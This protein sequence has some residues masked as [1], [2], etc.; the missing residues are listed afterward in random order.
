MPRPASSCSGL[1]GT[2][3][4]AAIV[5]PAVLGVAAVYGGKE[6]L[7]E[8]RRRL[9]DRRQQART[10][11]ADLIEEIRFQVDGRLASV[12]DEMQR[13]M[14]ARFMDRIVELH[15]TVAASA[16]A[17][18]RAAKRE[19]AE[20]RARQAEVDGTLGID[21]RPAR[22]G[23]AGRDR[24]PEGR[25]AR[26]VPESVRVAS[27]PMTDQPADRDDRPPGTRSIDALTEDFRSRDY[28]AD[29]SLG[30]GRLPG[31]RARPSAPAGGRGRRRQD[32]ARQGPRRVARRAPDP[33]AV[34][35]G[36][37]RQHRGVRVE[38]PAPD[39]RDPSARGARGGRASQRPGHLRARLPHPP[40]AAPGA[41]ERRWGRPGAAHRRDRPG[42]RGVRGIPPRDPVGLPGHGAR[43]SARS[44]R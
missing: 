35:R 40:A 17:L 36:P 15:R 4:G 21:R 37:R 26:T 33:A 16:A 10:F 5:G 31:A 32:R 2:L 1:V 28:I 41:R 38:L 7:D 6:V 34:L 22:S 29:R 39:A 9:T 23:R 11:L 42:R 3:L 43:R 19:T 44:R 20:R 27:E 30:D 14:R 18:D 25:T 13:Q 12:I 24:Q 8:R